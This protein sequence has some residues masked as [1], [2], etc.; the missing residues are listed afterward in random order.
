MTITIFLDANVLV[1]VSV[2]DLLLR[3]GEAGLID[4]HWSPEVLDEVARALARRQPDRP[5]EGLQRRFAAMNQAFPYA[6]TPADED[7]IGLFELPDPD[8]RHVAAAAKLC[9]AQIIVTHNI[10]DF[11]ASALDVHGLTAVTPDAL[12]LDLLTQDP[13]TVGSAIKNTAAATKSPPLTVDD[14]LVSLSKA[15][16][17][18]FVAAARAWLTHVEQPRNDDK[19]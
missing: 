14:I 11:P 18:G 5:P 19:P 1:P 13:E 9:E 17:P 7:T 8:D 4:P 3:L 2:T 10:K 12:L 16:L 6:S 15:H